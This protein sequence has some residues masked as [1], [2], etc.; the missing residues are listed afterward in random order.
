MM[1]ISKQTV[2]VTC[3]E[4]K[5]IIA[6][7]LKQ[8]AD[9]VLIKCSCGQKI[10]LEDHNGSNRRAIEKINKSFQDLGNTFKKFGR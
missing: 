8:V 2:S 4:C 10:Q 1:D 6:V 3:P 7:T 9:E 5:K